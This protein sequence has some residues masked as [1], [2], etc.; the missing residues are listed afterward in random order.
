L[1]TPKQ[2]RQ[3]V[4]AHLTNIEEFWTPYPIPSYARNE[5]MYTQYHQ[6]PKG[7]D[8]LYYFLPGHCNWRG[9]MW[10]HT[11][12]LIAHGL[13]NYDFIDEAEYISSRTFELVA[14]DPQL[15]EWY[16]AETGE[17]QGAHPFWAGSE[18]LMSFLH[19]EIQ[20]GF[21][22]SKIDSVL[23]KFSS[24]EIWRKLGITEPFCAEWAF[25]T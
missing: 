24:N 7:C 25:P 22:P 23:V 17:G 13:M 11:N 20:V 15:Y 19:T 5:P 18:V 14:A 6:T 8:P 21:D 12:Y 16:N 10:P 4:E 1:A 3:L 9:G 2:A